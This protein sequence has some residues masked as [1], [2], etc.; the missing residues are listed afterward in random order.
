MSEFDL[1]EM[2]ALY[3]GISPAMMREKMVAMVLVVFYR[4]VISTTAALAGSLL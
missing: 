3:E 1:L 4:I 2:A